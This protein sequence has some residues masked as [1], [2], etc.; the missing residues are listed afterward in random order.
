[1]AGTRDSCL[2]NDRLGHPRCRCPALKG[3][4]YKCG[5]RGRFGNVCMS[6]GNAAESSSTKKP[7]MTLPSSNLASASADSSLISV[8]VNK[9]RVTAL[10]DSGKINSFIHPNI[11]LRLNLIS[12]PAKETITMTFCPLDT[13]SSGHYLLTWKYMLMCTLT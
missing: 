8:L 9:V 1:M 7:V 12:P 13:A 2:L 11:A 6:S 10:V 4:C 3:V 5:K